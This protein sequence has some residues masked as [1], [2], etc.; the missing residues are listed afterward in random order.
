MKTF[1][2]TWSIEVDGETHED[3]AISAYNAIVDPDSLS[4]VFDVCT[5]HGDDPKSI[6]LRRAG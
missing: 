2:V 4:T 5:E 3:A 6:D 1:R